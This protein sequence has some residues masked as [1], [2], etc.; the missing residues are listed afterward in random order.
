MSGGGSIQDMNNRFRDNRAML[1]RR[2][3]RFK[4]GGG[5]FD[6]KAVFTTNKGKPDITT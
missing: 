6:E 5:F 4:S 2:K 3:I 1:G